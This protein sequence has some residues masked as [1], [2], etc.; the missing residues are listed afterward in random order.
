MSTEGI[1]TSVLSYFLGTIPPCNLNLNSDKALF[2]LHNTESDH[3]DF[4]TC[5]TEVI[6]AVPQ[7]PVQLS[8][9]GPGVGMWT[10]ELPLGPWGRGHTACSV[11][12]CVSHRQQSKA[13]WQRV[14]WSSQDHWPR[15]QRALTV[16]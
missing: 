2:V 9:D 11:R 5:K 10:W 1:F 15:P 6:N 14:S 13:E 8:G 12:F 3:L 16:S 7:A 4:I